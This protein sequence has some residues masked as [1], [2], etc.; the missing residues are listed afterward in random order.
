MEQ[1]TKTYLRYVLVAVHGNDALGCTVT[2]KVHM[3][4]R[5]VA[6]QMRYI[7]GGLGDKMD[8]GG[9]TASD[10]NAFATAL[11]TVQ[12][13][14]IRALAREKANSQSSHPDVIAHTNATNAGNKR[15]FSVVKVDD[16]IST[17]Q[18]RQRDMGRYEV[19]K[20]FDKE[21]NKKLTWLVIFDDV[22]AGG[23][24]EEWDSSAMP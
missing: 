18:K 2:P 24:V 14:V 13:P 11:C 21:V 8:L 1:D 4:L 16:A 20:Y 6:F 5:H 9:A 17:R 3:M 23:E 19:M 22:K 10:R 15:S 12:N 7:R